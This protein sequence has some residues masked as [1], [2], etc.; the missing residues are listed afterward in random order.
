ME[1]KIPVEIME[2]ENAMKLQDQLG[3]TFDWNTIVQQK[4]L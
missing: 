4:K 1:R 2:A 3:V